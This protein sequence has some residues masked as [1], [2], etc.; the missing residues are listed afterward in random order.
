VRRSVTLVMAAA[1]L[2]GLAAV[3]VAVPLGPADAATR[4]PAATL[5]ER[6]AHTGGGSQLITAVT[7]GT[8]NASR[9]GRLRLWN[10][11]KN[12]RWIQVGSTP[13]R[14]GVKGLSG[15]RVEGDGT[16]PT[17][18]F[19]LPTAFGIKA[20]P[21]TKLS[22]HAVN[23]RSWWNENS[24]SARYNTWHQN[25]PPS[26]CWRSSTRAAR[27]SE[28]LADYRPQYN[29]AVFIGFNAGRVKRVPP[30]RPSGSGIFLHVNGSG[31]TAGCI[32]VSQAAMVKIL[33]W[34]DPAKSPHIAIG[35]ARSIYRL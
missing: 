31:H 10:R 22:W 21:G 2:C 8:T 27:S 17:G 23:S 15:N 7:S 26:V 4:A 16:T 33:R 24:R 11:D 29:Y 35:N 25:C 28:H 18:I 14:F 6:M 1:S 19:T 3:G 5:P 13:A 20:D 32:S 9:D 34:L 30:A 12:N